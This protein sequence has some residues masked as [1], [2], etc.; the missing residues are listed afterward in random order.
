[1]RTILISGASRGIGRAIALRALEDGHRVSLGIRNLESVKDSK[2][3]PNV[4][5]KDKVI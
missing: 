3:D 1:M 5:G 2:L 4:S